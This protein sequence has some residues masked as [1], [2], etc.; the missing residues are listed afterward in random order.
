MSLGRDGGKLKTSG[1]LQIAT[2]GHGKQLLA[3]SAMSS[4][5]LSTLL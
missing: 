4:Q 1:R 5:S 3:S 2:D